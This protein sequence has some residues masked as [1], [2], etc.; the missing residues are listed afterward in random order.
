MC[1]G[2]TY[3]CSFF[4]DFYSFLMIIILCTQSEDP[5]CTVYGE[6][7]YV[8]FYT[9]P[10]RLGIRRGLWRHRTRLELSR[11]EAGMC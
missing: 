9:F 2:F 7:E 10:R 8:L 3:T 1:L 5:S 11:E 4:F 6:L